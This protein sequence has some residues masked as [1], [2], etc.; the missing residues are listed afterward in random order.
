MQFADNVSS[1]NGRDG[2][3]LRPG[4]TGNEIR[5]NLMERNVRY[6]IYADPSTADNVFYGNRMFD[7]VT[8][9]AGD[10]SWPANKWTA[11]QC[12]K[13]YPAGMIC[14]VG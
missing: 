4:N 13:D 6:G 1:D 8:L 7:N 14:G 2:L 9:D 12:V 10:G 5:D 11:N 3:W